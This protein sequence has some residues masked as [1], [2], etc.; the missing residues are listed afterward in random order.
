MPTADSSVP[1]VARCL[2]RYVLD[3]ERC[4]GVTVVSDVVHTTV[5]DLATL[6]GS[7]GA[8]RVDSIMAEADF[9]GKACQARQ[10]GMAEWLK[11][12]ARQWSRSMQSGRTTREGRFEVEPFIRSS[13]E[14]TVINNEFWQATWQAT[15]TKLLDGVTDSGF[16][17]YVHH[18]RSSTD[19]PH[20]IDWFPVGMTVFLSSIDT[21]SKTKTW[22]VCTVEERDIN[23]D[24]IRLLLRAAQAGST[25][26]AGALG[27]PG[28][29][30]VLKQSVLKRGLPAV[31]DYES[32]CPVI[33]P[34]ATGRQ[35]YY[36]VETNRL[37]FCES[38]LT[39][40]YI[41]LI[42]DNNPLYR[43]YFHVD[44][45][46]YNRQVQQD[47]DSRRAWQ[48]FFGDAENANQT[49]SNWTSLPEVTL[50]AEGLSQPWDGMVVSRKARAVGVLKQLYE[51][52]RVWDLQGQA[53]P[54]GELFNRF[55]SLR[56]IRRDN[57]IQENVIETMVDEGF[58]LKIQEAMIAYYNSRSQGLLRLNQDLMNKVGQGPFGFMYRSYVLDYP[59]GLEWRVVTHEFLNDWIDA[60][61]LEYTV[62]EDTFNLN[63]AAS[64]MWILDWANI[65][66]AILGSR[67][68]DNVSGDVSELARINS[69]FGCRMKVPKQTWRMRSWDRT[70][71]VECAKSSLAVV[72]FD[73]CTAPT[74]TDIA[75]CTTVF[76]DGFT[77]TWPDEPE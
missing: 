32:Y 65:Y 40:K 75:G 48:F 67:R 77:P 2:P 37:A 53:L 30:N 3:V 21:V 9:I 7:D 10:N 72:N 52:D 43:Q 63:N 4:A 13:I 18:V 50:D 55:A 24:N 51:C 62:G 6:Y 16:T 39:R 61:N 41:D 36:W 42:R 68:Q 64:T 60:H 47:W 31:T 20:H 74:I 71:V 28:V 35:A 56:R 45:V 27:L 22:A 70:V 38:E 23:G 76:F 29:G 15:T 73:R 26:P 57:G 49:A 54:L 12:T 1:L 33:P 58:A 66:E 11:A 44:D 25:A 34:I 17:G 5:A 14:D 8:W 19:I 69:G 59:T 46:K